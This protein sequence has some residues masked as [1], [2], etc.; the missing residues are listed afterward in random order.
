MKAFYHSVN[1]DGVVVLCAGGGDTLA[2][3]VVIEI[4]VVTGGGDFKT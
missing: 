4:F 2:L 1:V 3:Y